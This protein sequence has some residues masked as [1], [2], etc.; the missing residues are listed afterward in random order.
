MS[1]W[2][3]KPLRREE[4]AASIDD[5]IA[6]AS[7]IP[8]EYWNAEN[9]LLDL[10]EKWMLSLCAR[11]GDKPVGYAI[12]S[13]TASACAHLHHFMVASD[14]RG[15]GLGVDLLAHVKDRCE[16][17][18]CHGLSLKVARDNHRAQT[19]YRS[20]GFICEGEENGYLSMVADIGQN[21]DR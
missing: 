9:F 18:G 8:G 2:T 7:D 17:E 4:V 13:R 3:I 10:P 15:I 12:I 5:F 19:F 6:I 20:H 11:I 1:P 21:A 14:Q 16:S